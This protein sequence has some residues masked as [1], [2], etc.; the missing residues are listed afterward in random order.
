MSTVKTLNLWFAD[1]VALFNETTKQMKKQN[2][3]HPEQ[4][5]L[6]KPQSW[7][8]NTQRKDKVHEKPYEQRRHTSRSAKN[9]KRDRIQIH[10]T[11]HT[12]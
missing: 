12:P 5:K 6:R 11:N 4:S 3:K 10:R 2:K 8:K 7:L 9:L 1:D